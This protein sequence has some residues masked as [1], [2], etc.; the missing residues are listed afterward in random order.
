MG[1][2]EWNGVIG[3]EEGVGDVAISDGGGYDEAT[4]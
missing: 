4:F 1:Q 2:R 3:V